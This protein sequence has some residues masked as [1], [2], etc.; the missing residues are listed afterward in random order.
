[1]IDHRTLSRLLLLFSLLFT[2]SLSALTCDSQQ[3]IEIVSQRQSL[4]LNSHRMIFSG[5]V[6]IT[7]GSI[8]I[9]ADRVV[10]TRVNNQSGQEQVEAT[11]T[12]ATFYQLLEDQQPVTGS[13]QTIHYHAQKGSLILQQQAR[14]KLRDN[15]IQ[16][17]RITYDLAR[18]RVEADSAA[19]QRVKMILLPEQLQQQMNKKP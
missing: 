4:E 18:Q 1:M 5:Q 14:L 11:G 16:S 6:V 19:Q 9:R 8:K 3:P 7:Q 12:P 15:Q 10:V 13:S 2:G 17:D